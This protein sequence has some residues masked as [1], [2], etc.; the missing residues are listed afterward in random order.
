MKTISRKGEYQP[1]GIPPSRRSAARADPTTVSIPHS[2]FIHHYFIMN[3]FLSHTHVLAPENQL[4]RF[5]PWY[6]NSYQIGFIL[7]ALSAL[8]FIIPLIHF[9]AFY[10]S[11]FPALFFAHYAFVVIYALVLKVKGRLRL[12][13]GGFRE[14]IGC[15]L[16][17]LV[18]SLISCYALNQELPVFM[19]ATPWLAAYVVLTCLSLLAF[20]FREMLS[21]RWQTLLYG[22]VGA[23]AVL[24]LY[25]AIYLLPMV[26]FGI[27]A[28]L[29]LGVGL[30]A[31]VPLVGV[32]ILYRIFSHTYSTHR[33]QF[34]PLLLG[35]CIP[36]VMMGMCLGVWKQRLDHFTRAYNQTTLDAGLKVRRTTN[37]ST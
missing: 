4:P 14:N 8:L 26:G 25:L 33:R 28:A 27:I 7:V 21:S 19:E 11:S 37:A 6:D 30:H 23:A 36:I 20:S 1:Q 5:N 29:L 15:L 10:R 2:L 16:M 34:M 22:L 24:L 9:A 32:I 3:T 17:L 35:C 31:L 13:A 18:L 12:K